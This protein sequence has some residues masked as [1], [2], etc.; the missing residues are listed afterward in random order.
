MQHE[1]ERNRERELLTRSKAYIEEA[2]GEPVVG[3]RTRWAALTPHTIPIVKEL[4]YLYDSSMSADDAPYEL[5]VAG[6]PAGML[7]PPINVNLEDSTLD[8]GDFASG[9]FTPHSF[10]RYRLTPERHAEMLVVLADRR[11]G[12][13]RTTFSDVSPELAAS[14]GS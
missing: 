1:F 7:E 4:G 10:M 13:V 8:G 6:E 3:F 12:G 5:I 14:Q 2:L 9:M 11:Q